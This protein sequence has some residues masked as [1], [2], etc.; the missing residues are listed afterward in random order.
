MYVSFMFKDTNKTQYKDQSA[1][2]VGNSHA[3]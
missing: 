3:S 2:E 1:Y